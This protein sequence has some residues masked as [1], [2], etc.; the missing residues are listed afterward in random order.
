MDHAYS[1]PKHAISVACLG[2]IF[3]CKILTVGRRNLFSEYLCTVE[4]EKVL[5]DSNWVHENSTQPK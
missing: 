5:K 1:Y 2:Y 4:P 3:F